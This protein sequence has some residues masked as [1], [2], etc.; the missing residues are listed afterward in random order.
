[1]AEEQKVDEQ[2][3]DEQLIKVEKGK[4]VP[5]LSEVSKNIKSGEML[6]AASNL[7]EVQKSLL[8]SPEASVTFAPSVLRAEVEKDIKEQTTVAPTVSLKD[9]LSSNKPLTEFENVPP[10]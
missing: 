5:D 3:Q 10:T 9:L 6:Q 8:S 7:N 4:I 2:N 1:M